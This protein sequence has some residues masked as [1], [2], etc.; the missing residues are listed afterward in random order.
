VTQ[1][2][3]NRHARLIISLSGTNLERAADY[4]QRVVLQA[5]RRH[6]EMTRNDLVAI[7]GLTGSTIANISRR[8][9]ANGLVQEIERL[10]QGRG[11]PAVRLAI[12][13]DGAFG[14]GI[15]IDRDHLTM[16]TL[17]LAGKVRTR[18]SREIA[19]PNPDQVRDFVLEEMSR[20]FASG[21]IIPDRLIGAGVA[22]PQPFAKAGFHHQPPS[23]AMWD[24]TDIVALLAD[25]VP[26]PIHIDN[27]AAAA[28]LGELSFGSGHDCHSFFYMLV[29]AGLGGGLVIDG[30][31]Y[32]GASARSGEIGFIISRSA[33]SQ[34][35]PIE[36]TVSLS[37]L[38]ER[39]SE[40]GCPSGTLDVLE[41][42]DPHASA[43]IGEWIEQ[44]AETLTDPMIALNCLMNPQAVLIGGRLPAALID[45]LA[46]AL[47]E[48]LEV[49]AASMPYVAP[50]RRAA[51]ASD[52]PA[53]GAA[54]LPFSDR[55]LPS[56]AIL[57]NTRPERSAKR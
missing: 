1:R 3:N 45:K 44:A 20:I 28:A 5:I 48:R 34:G 27:D 13:P 50:V 38:Y 56:D 42:N 7:T 14:I 30:S 17:D 8:L 26:G 29:S 57:M 32:R 25:A 11:Q 16:V 23:Y 41:T 19:Y 9:V 51:M 54:L 15:N 37:A 40:A 12:D 35:L 33:A 6:E 39:L 18:T 10:Q 21:D 52:A 47:S 55:L 46:A 24:K 43:T 53:I 49:Y 36:T 22:V 2:P 31:F 4:N